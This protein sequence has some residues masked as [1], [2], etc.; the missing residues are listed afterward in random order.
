MT[1]STAGRGHKMQSAIHLGPGA[2][3]PHGQ[4]ARHMGIFGATGTGKTT[5]AA[6]LVERAPCPVLV[7]DVKGDLESLGTLHRPWQAQARLSSMGPDLIARALDLSEAQAGAVQIAAAWCQDNGV[8]LDTL[9]DMRR[10]LETCNPAP[11]GLLSLSSVAA[12]QR[13]MLRLERAA[14]WAFGAAVRDWRQCDGVEVLSCGALAAVPGL[15]GAIAAHILDSLY[16]GLGELGDVPAP[17]LMVLID[18]AHLIFDGATPAVVRRLEQV[19]RLIRSRGVGLIYVTQSPADLP[20]AI[21]G[22]LATRIQHGLRA[23][24]PRQLKGLR[25]AAESMPGGTV[26]AI[27]RLGTGHALV[28]VPD[29][30]GRPGKARVVRVARGKVQLAAVAPESPPVARYAA[31]LVEV[32]RVAAPPGRPWWRDLLR[33]FL[34]LWA[35]F[36]IV[37]LFA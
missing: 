22:Q 4:L 23:A 2:A 13:A 15:Y 20:D 1:A 17:G 19:T 34:W 21:A 11:Y 18:E 25:A 10:A 14:P 29:A 3:V 31:P 7:L 12:V 24:T 30:S 16:R 33:P 26:E 27:Q 6:A 28:S 9:Q 36:V 32:E 5:T 37:S 35:G 8:A